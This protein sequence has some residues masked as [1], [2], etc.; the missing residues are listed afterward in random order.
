MGFQQVF[1][2]S[3]HQFLDN[4]VGLIQLVISQEENEMLSGIPMLNEIWDTLRAMLDLKASGSYGFNDPFYKKCWDIVEVKAM[5]FVHKYFHSRLLLKQL[6]ATYITLI[7]KTKGAKVFRDFKLISLCNVIYN[8]LSKILRNHL[9][10]IM[11]K[12]ISPIQ[13]ILV[14]GSW[15]AKNVIFGLGDNSFFFEKRIV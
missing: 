5:E 14:L 11:N 12:L 3:C 4:L 15:I 6:N 7:L 13:S 10:G 2:R 9:L 8:I 1:N